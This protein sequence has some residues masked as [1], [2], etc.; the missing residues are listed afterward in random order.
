[1]FCCFYQVFEK[2][3]Q[4]AVTKLHGALMVAAEDKK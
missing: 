2:I 4:T 3:V 1:M